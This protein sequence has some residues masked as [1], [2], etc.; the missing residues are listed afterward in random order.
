MATTR[1]PHAP[2]LF[3]F[4]GMRVFQALLAFATLGLGIGTAVAAK[5]FSDE[6]NLY[7]LGLTIFLGLF[8]VWMFSATLKAPTSFVAISEDATR[9]RFGGFVDTRMPNSNILGAELATHH[10]IGGMGVRTN[11]HGDVALAS[12]AGKA[13]RLVFR[14][15]I[16]VWIIPR[17]LPVR[18]RRLTLTVIHPERLVERFGAPTTAP[19]KAD[20]KQKRQRGS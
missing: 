14:D 1:G 7:L 12:T 18:T 17:V 10:L 6:S 11:F 16:R 19:A 2:M 8:F 20:A 15:P 13:A 4:R 9:I 5:A 3:A